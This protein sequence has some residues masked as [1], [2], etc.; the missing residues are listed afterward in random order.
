MVGDHRFHPNRYLHRHNASDRVVQSDGLRQFLRTVCL[1]IFLRELP[2]SIHNPDVTPLLC[3]LEGKA[4]LIRSGMAM[5][6]EWH[7]ECTSS[8]W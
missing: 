1:Q 3:S 7:P 8:V 6:L 2:W 5:L 4:G